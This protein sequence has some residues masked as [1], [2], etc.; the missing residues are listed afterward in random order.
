MQMSLVLPH[1]WAMEVSLHRII[2]CF[3]MDG[4]I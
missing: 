2:E 4:T 1:S 3:D